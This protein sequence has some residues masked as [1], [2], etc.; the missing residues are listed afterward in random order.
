MTFDRCLAEKLAYAKKTFTAWQARMS[1]PETAPQYRRLGYRDKVCL[2]AAHDNG[3][4]HIGLKRRDGVLA[5]HQCPIHGVRVR[6]ALSLFADILPVADGFPLAFYAQSGA[7]VTLVVKTARLP[8][9][10]WLDSGVK[11]RLSEAGIEG[12]WVC[13]HPSAGHRVFARSGWRRVWGS[14]RSADARGLVYGPTTFGQPIFE[15]AEKALITAETFLGPA[16]G[17][18]VIDLYCGIGAGLVRWRKTTAHVVGVE[19]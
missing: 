7:Q 19:L 3:A 8:D 10:T 12:L 15:L 9:M 2:A 6:Q 11:Q 13:L 14:P 4:W 16:A 18:R 17:D 1:P 5:I